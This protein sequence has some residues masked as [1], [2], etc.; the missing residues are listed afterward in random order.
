[1]RLRYLSLRVRLWENVEDTKHPVQGLSRLDPVLVDP[2]EKPASRGKCE[3]QAPENVKSKP[4]GVHE[5]EGLGSWEG[6]RTLEIRGPL[7]L[8]GTALSQCSLDNHLLGTR[9]HC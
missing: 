6:P 1:M 5:W 7:C 2:L 3:D 8:E 9:T 4:T